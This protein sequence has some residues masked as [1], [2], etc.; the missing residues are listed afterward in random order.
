MCAVTAQA[1]HRKNF[2][3]CPKQVSW[4]VEIRRQSCFSCMFYLSCLYCLSI[5]CVPCVMS[6][7][8]IL[9][10]LSYLSVVFLSRGSCQ[11]SPQRTCLKSLNDRIWKEV[12]GC[13]QGSRR[14]SDLIWPPTCSCKEVG[15]YLTRFVRIARSI[16]LNRPSSVTQSVPRVGIEL[17]SAMTAKNN[18]FLHMKWNSLFLLRMWYLG[19]GK[20]KNQWKARH[21]WVV[22][23]MVLELVQKKYWCYSP[24]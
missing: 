23:W 5:L 13:T 3:S 19:E 10:V 15:G 16:T 12:K 1:E 18:K 8:S 9:S 6:L 20:G 22:G 4:K 14:L 24:E 17:G 11:T 2:E 7:Q 21:T